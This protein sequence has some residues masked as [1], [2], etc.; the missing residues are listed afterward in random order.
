MKNLFCNL[1]IWA[2]AVSACCALAASADVTI[3]V[4]YDSESGS[5]YPMV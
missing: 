1:K 3:W 4:Y 2:L 5:V